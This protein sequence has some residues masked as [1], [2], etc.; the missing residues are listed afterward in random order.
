MDKN[1][2]FNIGDEVI[3]T[4]GER[5]FIV[6]ICECVECKYRGFCEPIWEDADG[7]ETYITVYDKKCDFRDYYKIGKYRFGNFEKDRLKTN[8]KA[9]E[10]LLAG[11]KGRLAFMEETEK[12]DRY[13]RVFDETCV[14]W[15]K[16]SCMNKRFL[17][18]QQKYADHKLKV[19]GHLFLNEVYDMLGMPR[20]QFGQVAGWIYDPENPAGP[21]FVSSGIYDEDANDNNNTFRLRFN[22]MDNILTYLIER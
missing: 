22:V 10:A 16:D 18:D 7:H 15:T 19:R 9:T 13:T 12:G 11:S 2:E 4:D 20:T 6:D 21:D 5:G 3:T 17:L 1:Y 8:I 14:G